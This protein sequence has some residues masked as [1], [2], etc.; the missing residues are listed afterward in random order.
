[1]DL[2]VPRHSIDSRDIQCNGGGH[3]SQNACPVKQLDVELRM[4]GSGSIR[5][6]TPI[7]YPPF[8]AGNIG[9]CDGPSGCAEDRCGENRAQLIK[10][11]SRKYT[12]QRSGRWENGTDLYVVRWH[13]P[14]RFDKGHYHYTT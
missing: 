10:T 9:V 8:I 14:S 4:N 1:M 13:S 7:S 2:K 3:N 12:A 5:R 11:M 6:S